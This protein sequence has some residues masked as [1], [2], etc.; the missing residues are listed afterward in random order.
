MKK[1]VE[2][3]MTPSGFQVTIGDRS[4]GFALLDQALVVAHDWLRRAR[5]RASCPHES[6][7]GLDLRVSRTASTAASHVGIR[8][9]ITRWPELPTVPRASAKVDPARFDDLVEP[10]GTV[11]ISE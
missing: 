2:I 1:T 11:A 4:D 7:D 6:N 3:R 8:K 10:V 5:S 9:L